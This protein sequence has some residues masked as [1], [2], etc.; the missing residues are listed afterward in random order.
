MSDDNQ[1]IFFNILHFIGQWE[2]TLE[3][4]YV[5]QYNYNIPIYFFDKIFVNLYR[6]ELNT[7][8]RI[9]V[10]DDSFLKSSFVQYHNFKINLGKCNIPY[11]AILKAKIVNR[12][13]PYEYYTF[14]RRCVLADNIFNIE[15]IFAHSF[16]H[17]STHSFEQCFDD[18]INQLMKL[19]CHI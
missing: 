2:L 1:K 13:S 8:L 10:D 5:L 12:E 14:N 17:T 3:L 11:T 9:K 15:H 4:A 18:L 16:E 6:D 19:A 7:I